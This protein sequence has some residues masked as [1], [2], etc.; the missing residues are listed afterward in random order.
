[1]NMKRKLFSILVVFVMMLGLVP[2]TVLA[3]PATSE[4]YQDGTGGGLT[5]GA[6]IIFQQTIPINLVFLGYD[7][8]AINRQ[9]ILNQLPSSYYPIVRYPAFYGLPGRNMGLKYDFTYNFSLVSSKTTDKFFKYL[10]L[11]GVPSAPT[12]F[13]LMYN[14]MENNVLDVPDSVLFVDAPAVEDWLNKNVAKKNAGYTIVFIN[15]YSRPDFQFHVYTKTDV[16]DPDTGYNFGAARSSRK[17]IAWGG[18]S[19]RVWFYDLSAGP[20]A[21][22]GNYDVDN[23]DLDGNGFED[24]RMPPIWEYS[25]AGYRDPAALSTDLGLVTRFV[26]I[27][28]LFATSPLY[29][30]LASAPEVNGSKIVHINMMEDDPASLGTDWISPS[31]AQNE[32]KKFEPYYNWQ[33]NL[34]DVNPIDAGAQNAFRVWSGLVAQ[35]D[36]WNDYGDPFAELFCYFDINRSTYI[37]AYGDA[38]YVAAMHAFNTTDENLGG[39]SGLLGFADD[40]WIDGTPSYVFAFDTEYYRSI[41]YG[42]STTIT[43]EGGHHIGMSHPHDGYDSELGLDYGAADD[44]YFAN[45]GDESNT[46]MHYMDLSDEFGR[47]D[48]DN[49]YRWEMAGYLN[50][51]NELA[52]D[53]LANPNAATVQ[54]Y[55]TR[56]NKYAERALRSFGEWNYLDAVRSARTAYDQLSLAAN[57]LG[58]P[59]PSMKQAPELL[60]APNSNFPHEG[61]PIRFPDN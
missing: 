37:P 22:T 30:P 18:S 29:D 52:S 5:P 3:A 58:I 20:E 28:L 57:L 23:L 21:W 51:S 45:S 14:D 4:G 6:K 42:F 55:I 33:V 25:A 59:T 40:N 2:A 46:I 12:A 1:M 41:G 50:W 31:F 60:I 10:N 53:I 16:V 36:C 9:E 8:S 49:M 24:Y 61:D 56:A 43:H 48:Q 34:T 47:F 11:I 26:G 38:D 32:F 13:Q 15:W 44:F 27:D 54:K 17:M 19:S 7:Q 39:Y 35:D